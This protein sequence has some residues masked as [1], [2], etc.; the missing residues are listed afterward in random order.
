MRLPTNWPKLAEES[1]TTRQQV[2]QAAG[3]QT[4]AIVRRFG[5]SIFIIALL[6][7][8]AAGW[9]ARWAQA[10]HSQACRGA[11][12]AHRPC[13]CRYLASGSEALTGCRSIWPRRNWQRMPRGSSALACPSGTPHWRCTRGGHGQTRVPLLCCPGDA[14]PHPDANA[15]FPLPAPLLEA[16]RQRACR[17]VKTTAVFC[18]HPVFCKWIQ[19]LQNCRDFLPFLPFKLHA[20]CCILSE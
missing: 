19:K 3:S 14:R 2:R 20:N 15:P 12:G 17:L 13:A 5:G 1:N 8:G 18:Q 16:Q 4:S 9:L 6:I 11:I 10:P 7:L